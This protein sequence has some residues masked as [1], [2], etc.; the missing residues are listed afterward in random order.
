MRPATSSPPASGIGS[1]PPTPCGAS[2]PGP[3]GRAL[4]GP[5]LHPPELRV[6]PALPPESM[7][8]AVALGVGVGVGVSVC[9]GV[10]GTVGGPGPG[11]VLVVLCR[12]GAWGAGALAYANPWVP[13]HR[14][15]FGMGLG[16]GASARCGQTSGA[17]RGARTLLVG[18]GVA[19]VRSGAV[20]GPGVRVL[21][22]GGTRCFA[23]GP[24][25][26]PT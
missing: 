13:G 7:G 4:P 24:R 22:G 12:G 17:G 16:S 8:G 25:S 9:C 18:P 1:S 5:L 19:P 6:G 23:P 10:M 14:L 20:C 2:G 3:R 21:G 15:R 11:G 26:L